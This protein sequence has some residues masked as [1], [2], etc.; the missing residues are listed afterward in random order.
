MQASL[1]RDADRVSGLALGDAGTLNGPALKKGCALQ[2][3]DEFGQF[4]LHPRRVSE[5][6][7]E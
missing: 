3:R 6:R 5:P 2:S 1:W 7:A 4:P